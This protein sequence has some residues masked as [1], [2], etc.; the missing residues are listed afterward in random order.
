MHQLRRKPTTSTSTTSPI[1]KVNR[2]TASVCKLHG[3]IDWIADDKDIVMRV[4]SSVIKAD[5]GNQQLLIYPQATKYQVTQ[6]DPFATLFS[7]FRASLARSGPSVLVVCGYS[8]G[9]DHVNEEIERALRAG[10]SGLTV[11]AL[12]FQT[13]D[14]NGNLNDSQ[15][16]PAVVAEWLQDPEFGSRVVVAGSHGYYRNG[17]QSSLKVDMPLPWCSFAG[18]TDFLDRG[19]EALV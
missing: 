17:L 12:C 7:D 13:T 18:I 9:D 15:G 8:F 14:K 1:R 19:V 10:P 2:H 11:V 6:R 5:D 4:R 3:S 16:I